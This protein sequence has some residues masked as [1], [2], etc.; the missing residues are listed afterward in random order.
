MRK[1]PSQ[2]NRSLLGAT[3]MQTKEDKMFPLD[4]K[5][6]RQIPKEKVISARIGAESETYV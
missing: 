6:I 3:Q 2:M 1:M 4:P 5:D